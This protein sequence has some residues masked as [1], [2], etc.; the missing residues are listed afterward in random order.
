M[1]KIVKNREQRFKEDIGGLKVYY[2][3]MR[4]TFM[5]KNGISSLQLLDD[6][7]RTTA[8]PKQIQFEK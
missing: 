3:Q 5:K 7:I 6:V 8:N 2:G 1:Q 4:E